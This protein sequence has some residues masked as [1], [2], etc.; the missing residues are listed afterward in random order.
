MGARVRGKVGGGDHGC[1]EEAGSEGGGRLCLGLWYVRLFVSCFAMP[2]QHPYARLHRMLLVMRM[3]RMG[4]RQAVV[5]QSLLMGMAGAAAALLFDACTAVL[6]YLGTGMKSG[7]GV[8]RFAELPWWYCMAL[9]ALGAIPAALVLGHALRNARYPVPEYMEAFSLGNG[10]LPR[11]QGVWRSL[12]AVLSLASGASIGKEGALI[13]ISSVA[14]SA[15]GR[16]L[17]VSPVRLRLLVG[18]GAAA[19]MTAAFHTP[20]SACLF[21]CEVV[22][23][24]F[25]IATLAPL[26]LASCAAYMLLWLLGQPG[27]LFAV[28]LALDSLQEALLC[29]LLAVV[30]ALLGK[31]WVVLLD[32][33]RRVL[34]GRVSWLL[35]RMVL[36]GVAVG[37]VALLEPYVIGNGY[38]AIRELAYGQFSA[39]EAAA[40]LGIKALLVAVVFGVGTMGGVLTPTL[41]IGALVGYLFGWGSSMCGVGTPDS[42]VAYAFVGMAAFFAVAGRAPVTALLLVIEFTMSAQLIFPLMVAVGV[43]YA[44]GR[45]LPG[46]SLYDASVASGPASAFDSRLS[47][48]CV[49]DLCRPL[50]MRVGVGTSMDRVMRLMLRHP[51]ENVP[52]Q[53]ETGHCVGVVRPSLVPQDLD[54]WAEDAGAAMDRSLPILRSDQRLPEALA[55]FQQVDCRALPVAD[56]SNGRL[57]G[58]L[59][60]AE[61]YQVMALMFR[62]ELAHR[63]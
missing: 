26:L 30:A 23:G 4:E 36:A 49:A 3:L 47:E 7:S 24:T 50:R 13:Q 17:Y 25:S 48:L 15:M 33:C 21:V 16:W 62:R 1:K 42:A 59:S 12:S 54:R 58:S 2:R 43:A 57:M 40:L 28:P 38:E 44:V 63:R 31:G 60:R 18:C 46:R 11:R 52:V 34:N 29:A 9:P 53:D 6:Q 56:A 10:C 22:V 51:G 37:V 41:L 8:E 20:L 39:G 55:A 14:A 27:A 32:F 45:L 5:L 35:P 61:L 19:G